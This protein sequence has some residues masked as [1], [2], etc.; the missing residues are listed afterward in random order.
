MFLA[1]KRSDYYANYQNDYSYGLLYAD[2][3]LRVA[4]QELRDVLTLYPHINK[5]VLEDTKAFASLNINSLL[6][7]SYLK[8]A[9]CW[10]MLKRDY[11]DAINMLEK[12]LEYDPNRFEAYNQMGILYMQL[13]EWSKA[14]TALDFV[15]SRKVDPDVYSDMKV[16]KYHS[17]CN[18][19]IALSNLNMLKESIEC[20]QEA[21]QLDPNGSTALEYM[22]NIEYEYGNIDR[23]TEI[24]NSINS[25]KKSK[26]SNIHWNTEILT[27]Y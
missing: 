3:A 2:E 27:H 22:L 1:L 26:V 4:S 21:I 15:C 6:S 17:L 12:A 14:V 18:K 7:L 11:R 25:L 10:K 16:L 19:S 20:L 5:Y 23:A 13:Q 9:Q 24:H 8:K